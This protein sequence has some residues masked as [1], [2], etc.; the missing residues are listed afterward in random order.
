MWCNDDVLSD[1]FIKD[2]SNRIGAK[3]IIITK[4]NKITL[5]NPVEIR[6]TIKAMV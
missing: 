6:K 1:Y 2:V 4:P 5:N 3:S